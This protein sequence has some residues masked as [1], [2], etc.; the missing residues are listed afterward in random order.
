MP[1][2][3]DRLESL[4]LPFA[5]LPQYEGEQDVVGTLT[6]MATDEVVSAVLKMGPQHSFALYD[7]AP[8]IDPSGVAATKKQLHDQRQFIAAWLPS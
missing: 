7:Q 2:P 8:S 5:V 1:R 4:I 6:D 3:P